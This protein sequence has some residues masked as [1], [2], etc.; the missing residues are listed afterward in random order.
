MQL[1]VNFK[2]MESSDAL[3]TYAETKIEE[4][5]HKLLFKPATT[6]LTL[7]IE[8]HNNTAHLLF[9]S[10]KVH[11][12]ATDV[13]NDMY[14]SIDNVADKLD[15]QLK[16]HLAKQKNHHKAVGVRELETALGTKDESD[17]EE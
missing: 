8:R 13:S 10:G 17:D 7:S 4:R 12:E 3:R 6:E 9:Q 1:R 11:L 5:I 15:Q 2:N 14:V 16:K